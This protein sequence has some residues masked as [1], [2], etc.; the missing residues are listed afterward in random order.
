MKKKV[1][2]L[3]LI[4]GFNPSF[5]SLFHFTSWIRTPWTELLNFRPRTF[6]YF[7]SS[8]CW[9]RK[10]SRKLSPFGDQYISSTVIKS[11]SCK[12]WKSEMCNKTIGLWRKKK[13][14]P[15]RRNP[16]H[17]FFILA[18]NRWPTTIY[19]KAGQEKG[20]IFHYTPQWSRRGHG[21]EGSLIYGYRF[22]FIFYVAEIGWRDLGDI[23]RIRLY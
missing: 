23:K 15:N 20:V 7:H 6:T 19:G 1:S 12:S 14:S 3:T 22:A 10:P 4:F 8:G 21:K 17:T 16:L 13:I 18:R 11:L 9:K 5:Y 2:K